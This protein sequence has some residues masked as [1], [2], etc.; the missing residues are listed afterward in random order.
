MTWANSYPKSTIPESRLQERTELVDRSRDR[1]FIARV[2]RC[3][4]TPEGAERTPSGRLVLRFAEFAVF[5]HAGTPIAAQRAA[6]GTVF[7]E[8]GEDGLGTW[9][10][11]MPDTAAP[12]TRRRRDR[13][14]ATA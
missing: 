3:L 12:K 2:E 6:D 1:E 11:T 10:R 4:G 14:P 8:V 9:R 5:S 13:P 7:A